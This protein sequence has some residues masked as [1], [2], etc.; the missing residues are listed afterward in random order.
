MPKRVTTQH[1]AL[2]SSRMKERA[3][4]VTA[5]DEAELEMLRGWNSMTNGE[6]KWLGMYAWHD[7]AVATSRALGFSE[8]FH[9]RRMEINP[10]FRE[11][12]KTRKFTALRISRMLSVDMMGMAAVTHSMMVDP[13]N[14]LNID[15]KT[16]V[17]AL[18][19]AYNLHGM[20]K[21]AAPDIS[22]GGDT[23]IGTQ[24][25]KMFDTNR[26]KDDDNEPAT[27]EFIDADVKSVD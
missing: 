21:N 3:Q 11:A 14:P 19:L 18:K 15:G 25:I 4:E 22:K 24:N 9:I 6:K 26:I 8:K 7:T 27:P 17:E 23:F 13:T 5:F 2:I 1:P 20:L 16:Q 12:M 10:H